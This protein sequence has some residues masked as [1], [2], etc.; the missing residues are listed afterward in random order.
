MSSSAA[1]SFVNA[2]SPVSSHFGRAGLLG[3]KYPLG[4]GFC[5][6]NVST[7][8]KQRRAGRSSVTVIEFG[9]ERVQPPFEPGNVHV[10]RARSLRPSAYDFEPG[11]ASNGAPRGHELTLFD[12][13]LWPCSRV[14]RV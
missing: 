14:V 12:F 13:E 7:S 6:G 4:V 5:A 9:P 3:V 8:S 2:I 1:N 11:A 10:D